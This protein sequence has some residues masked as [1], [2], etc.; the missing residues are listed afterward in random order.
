MDGDRDR[1]IGPLLAMTRSDDMYLTWI[2]IL[3][4]LCYLLTG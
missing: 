2:L 1:D 3:Y 4:L